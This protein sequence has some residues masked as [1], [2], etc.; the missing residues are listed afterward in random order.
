MSLAL[1]TIIKNEPPPDLEEWIQHYERLGAAAVL[2]FDHGS[3]SSSTQAALGPHVERGFVLHH[4]W[5]G[6]QQR[7]LQADAY[8]ACLALYRHSFDFLAFLDAD[9]F[10]ALRDPALSLPDLLA[11]FTAFGGLALNWQTFGPSGHRTRPAGGLVA[12]YDKCLPAWHP[13]E[14]HVKL[15]VNTQRVL[16]MSGPHTATF[17]GEDSAV[18]SRGL[19]VEGPW[20]RPAVHDAVWLAHYGTR[21]RQ[22]YW[23]HKIERGGANGA[24]KNWRYFVQLKHECNQTCTL[25]RDRVRSTPAP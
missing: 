4:P 14:E 17:W 15:I 12:S 23:T 18:N 2:L 13:I 8:N 16:S 11:N 9:E 10:V 20:S 7:F 22:D 24:G 1:C 3:D 5:Q 21:S 25:L 6:P 19:R